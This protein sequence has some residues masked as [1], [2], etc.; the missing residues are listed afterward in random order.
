MV[1][2]IQEL[3]SVL[4]P[5]TTESSK[6]YSAEVSR[7]DNEGTVWVYLE[8]ST[9]ETPTASTS[10]EV[11][12]GDTVNVN[13]RNNKLYIE[14]NYSDPSAGVVRVENIEKV[15]ASADEK[16]TG[17]QETAIDAKK[18]AGNTNQYF[19]VTET[20]TDTGAHITEIPQESF[21]RTPSGG[22]LLA[23]SNG[24]A[25]RSGLNELATFGE[26]IRVGRGDDVR[27]EL[28]NYGMTAISSEGTPYFNVNASGA[29]IVQEVKQPVVVQTYE[30]EVATRNYTWNITDIIPSAI[31]NT[32]SDGD[33]FDCTFW[34]IVHDKEGSPVVTPTEKTYMVRTKRFVKGT[35]KGYDE[36][37]NHW[38]RVGYNATNETMYMYLQYGYDNYY[39][40]K[41]LCC[42]ATIY[43]N[44]TAPYYAIGANMSDEGKALGVG[45]GNGTIPSAYGIAMGT[46]NE[47]DANDDY[48]FIIGNGADNENRSNALE[49]TWNG[50][51]II[52]NGQAIRVKH[53]A[54]GDSK[55][56]CGVN[57]SDQYIFGWGSYNDGTDAAYYEGNEVHLR[58]RQTNGIYLDTG[59]NGLYKITTV[60]VDTG[61]I[62]ANS[63]K[64]VTTYSM[65]AQS[66]YNAVG[67][68]GWATGNW[69][70]QP[71]SHYISSNTALYAGFANYA[72][73]AA[74]TTITFRVLW[75]KAT[76]A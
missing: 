4:Q 63:Y 43:Q 58:S 11:K 6:T 2:G 7:V 14:G 66:G 29:S 60:A 30:D 54:T 22:N 24:I 56:L 51:I 55:Y 75:L 18:I 61:S 45:F 52:P 34:G 68:V 46:Y 37:T 3:I 71:T 73:S 67:I 40:L 33:P 59:I 12:R 65:P 27:I 16:A 39:Y 69:R 36:D 28:N 25:V 41:S 72:S 50:S 57:A 44:K 26:T 13:W 19:W 49:V 15:A 48:A 17:A 21:L 23:R 42:Q 47:E 8:G 10:S 74:D 64:G 70:I 1:D 5:D 9:K 32:L 76:S 53:K 38:L 35:T 31:W 62:A 20:G